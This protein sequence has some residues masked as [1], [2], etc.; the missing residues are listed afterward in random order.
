MYT[1]QCLGKMKRRG[2]ELQKNDQETSGS[3]VFGDSQR[4]VIVCGFCL[5]L[6]PEHPDLAGFRA[7]PSCRGDEEK[8]TASG[9]EESCISPPQLV[10]F[11]FPKADAAVVRNGHLKKELDQERMCRRKMKRESLD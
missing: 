8:E 10:F 4:S 5:C 7:K 9:V 3:S 1:S 11:P 2:E 6:A